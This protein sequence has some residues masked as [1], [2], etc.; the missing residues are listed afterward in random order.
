MGIEG[1]GGSLVS[2]YIVF[3]T[4]EGEG[5]K[6]GRTLR[7]AGAGAGVA[8]RLVEC[9]PACGRQNRHSNCNNFSPIILGGGGTHDDALPDGDGGG[10][11]EAD[12]RTEDAGENHLPLPPPPVA[13]RTSSIN[14]KRANSRIKLGSHLHAEE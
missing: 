9:L 14:V 7:A 8:V 5:K 12:G 3:K 10:A 2:A 1:I 4:N 11:G 6:D 13:F